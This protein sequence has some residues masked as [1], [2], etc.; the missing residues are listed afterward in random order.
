MPAVPEISPADLARELLNG[1]ELQVL[2]VRAPFRLAAGRVDLG[3]DKRF[4][5]LAG[6][7]VLGLPDPAAAGLDR[8]LPVAVVCGR[9]NDSRALAAHLLQHGFRA[10]SLAGGMTAWMQTLLPYELEAPPGFERL[11]QFDR[12]G[13]GALSYLLVSGGAALVI[14]P[15]RHAQAIEAAAQAAGARIVAVAETHA[16]ADYLS[17]GRALADRHG[18]AYY[19]HP[20]DA[21]SPYDGTP[22]RIE[23]T[24]LAE[25]QEL[26]IGAGRVS[27]R[28]TPGHTLGS[29]SFLVDGAAA[30][31]GDFLFVESIGRPD[32]GGRTAEWTPVLYASLDRARR[33][34]PDAVRIYPAHYAAAR[35]RNADH[36]V[37]RTLGAIKAANPT[38]NIADPAAFQ[39][40]VDS[41]V[42]RPPEAYRRIKVINIGLEQ[43]E[44]PAADELESG[45]NECAVG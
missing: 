29:V 11:V 35:E 19:L 45:K 27:V 12:V 1:A 17:G 39:A 9:G 14:D 5:N 38:V 44:G 26:A 22:G 6:S 36:S 34:W 31:T 40:W 41:H 28:H 23:Y 3:P 30:F 7:A 8:G 4:V 25:G 32:L 10:S 24:P 13:K 16:H 2:D 18:A 37:W 43:L 42:S 21:A 33:E 20:A 15:P